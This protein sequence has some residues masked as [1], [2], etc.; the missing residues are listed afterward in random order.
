MQREIRYELLL[1]YLHLIQEVLRNITYLLTGKKLL[2]LYLHRLMKKKTLCNFLFGCT[3]DKQIK[4]TE[5][6]DKF[7]IKILKHLDF[8]Q[9]KV[10]V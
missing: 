2:L 6:L 1:K 3:F 4:A 9:N 5:E 7:K 10:N 8:Q